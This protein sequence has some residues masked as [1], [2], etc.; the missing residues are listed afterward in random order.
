MLHGLALALVAYLLLA[1]IGSAPARLLLRGDGRARMLAFAPLL[2]LALAMAWLDLLGYFLPMRIVAWTIPPLAAAS[3]SFAFLHRRRSPR[4]M[5]GLRRDVFTL[6]MPTLVALVVGAVPLWIAGR[7]TISALTNDDATYYVAAAEQLHAHAW[8][9][10]LVSPEVCLSERLVHAWYWRVGVPDLVAV[11]STLARVSMPAALG[12][13][14][15]LLHALL[16][17]GALAFFYVAFPRVSSRWR[18]TG[19]RARSTPTL[20][21]SES[22]A[23]ALVAI[24]AAP[25]F[26][27]YQQL[28]GQLSAFV[29]F[30][31]ACAS[32]A[33]AL[34]RRGA[35]PRVLA[36]VLVGAGL[37]VFADGGVV[38]IVAGLAAIAATP[39]TLRARVSRSIGVALVAAF[40]FAPTVVRAG[41]AL[42]GTLVHRVAASKPMFPQGGWLPRT[43]LDDLTTLAGTDPWPPWPAPKPMTVAAAV[44]WLGALAVV[45]LVVWALREARATR[46]SWTIV[47][48]LGL[49]VVAG[50]AFATTRYLVGKILLMAA[51]FVVP[52][53]ALALVRAIAR[54]RPIALAGVVW[55]IAAVMAAASLMRPED[56]HVIDGPAHDRLVTELG[57]LPAGSFVALDGFGALADDAHDE[58]RAYRAALLAHLRPIQPG[59]DGGFYR[60]WCRDPEPYS[61]LPARAWALQRTTAETLSRGRPLAVFGPFVL[62]EV[63]LATLD[64]VA[65]S[66]AP[67]LGWL[68]AE[69]APD[70]SVFRW[71][72]VEA[73]A[74]LRVMQSSSCARLEGELRTVDT[75][76]ALEL[77]ASGTSIARV[78]LSPVWTPFTT[79]PF[80]AG[81]EQALVFR[82]ML[83]TPPKDALRAF[84]LR[85]LTVA[86]DTSCVAAIRRRDRPDHDPALPEPL[87]GTLSY[88]VSPAAGVTCVRVVATI[89]GDATEPLAIRVGDDASTEEAPVTPT[90][91]STQLS[92][93]KLSVSGPFPVTVRRLGAGSSPATIASL[94]AIPCAAP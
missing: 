71:A 34:A 29:L 41:Y 63:D 81:R 16:P 24:A 60:N 83:A 49:G 11:T 13:V 33:L 14:T 88:S 31:V 89:T 56:F 54:R 57:A 79:A 80:D 52:I 6:A 44:A 53:A 75:Y 74:T 50:E 51:A 3:A 17:A 48:A 91:P 68:G 61:P 78:A 70:G 32:F 25:V 72:G 20:L 65:G 93:R 5:G 55:S 62:R 10:R 59:P 47:A 86:H 30:P 2:G 58:H 15:A 42:R 94:R 76:G 37:A 45:P 85:R 77:Q 23:G 4:V 7:L 87:E 36:G 38:M 9:V 92:S 66:Y 21:P 69:R 1:A 26:L 46:V 40:A 8:R 27:A 12:V 67:T 18:A 35:R 39:A 84:A 73:Y 43:V 82:A 19:R 28:L 64:G 22:I 90:P